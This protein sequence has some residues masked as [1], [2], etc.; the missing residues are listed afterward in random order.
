MEP[1]CVRVKRQLLT[2]MIDEA[3]VLKWARDRGITVPK[4]AVREA[5]QDYLRDYEIGR[6]SCRERV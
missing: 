3:L 1:D 6:A 2:R 4:T 5:E